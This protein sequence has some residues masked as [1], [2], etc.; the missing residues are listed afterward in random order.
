MFLL[1]FEL[2]LGECFFN[3]ITQMEDYRF[4][5][6]YSVITQ[7]IPMVLYAGLLIW[8]Y[9]STNGYEFVSLNPP[10]YI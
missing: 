5:Q 6:T 3:C 9:I 1:G 2:F 10:E 8:W 4:Y 7:S